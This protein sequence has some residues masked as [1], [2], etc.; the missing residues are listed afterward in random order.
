MLWY[1]DL[2]MVLSERTRS[3]FPLLLWKL[4]GGQGC[5]IGIEEDV[6]IVINESEPS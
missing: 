5:L 3:P 2:N 1:L 4:H 6:L